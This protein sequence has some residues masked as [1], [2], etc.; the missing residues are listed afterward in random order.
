M[1]KTWM[2]LAVAAWAGA[3][4]PLQGQ[5]RWERGDQGWCDQDRSGGDRER[6]CEVLTT[7]L[8]APAGITVNG[9]A[10]GGVVVSGWDRSEVQIRAKVW[11]DA[12]SEE[13]AQEIEKGVK[14]SVDGGR[15][16]SDGPDTGRRESWGVSYEIM[17]PRAMDLDI[18]T[19]NGGVSV[20]DVSGDIRFRAMNG[21][22][23]LVRVG[24]DVRGRTT[25]GGLTVE[26]AGDHWEG[27][28]LDAQTTNGGVKMVVPQD[29]SAELVTGTV[30]GGMNIDFPITVRGRIGRQIRTTLGEGG[31]TI[32][33]TTTNGGVR[34]T[35]G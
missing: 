21:G 24:G 11:A 22:V 32:R 33:V 15:I 8:E 17:V 14:I 9:G 19:R 30:N 29:Y 26:L 31:A 6:S 10:N 18:D 35:R 20:T 3:G 25:N 2:L 4:A 5:V 7:T 34:I 12:P 27:A 28:G 1:K 13:R 16:S 23:H